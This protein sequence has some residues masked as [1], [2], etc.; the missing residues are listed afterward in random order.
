MLSAKSNNN[1]GFAESF[2]L[3]GTAAGI[4]KTSAAPIERVKLLLQNQNEL[5]K[6]G[7]LS[8]KFTGVQDCVVKTLRN[9]GIRSFWRGN[10]ASVVRY[11]PQQALNFTFK[12]QIK[13][14]FKLPKNATNKEK[15]ATNIMS[16][17]CAGSLSLLFVQ[18]IDYT[19]TRLAMDAAKNAGKRTRQFNGIIDCYVKTMKAD[20]IRGLYRGFVISCIC[21]FIYRGLYFGLYD[22]LKPIILGN[23]K[24]IPWVH[25]FLLGWGV[26]IV[27][28]LT[29]YPIDTVKRRMMMTSGEKTKYAGSIDCF[30]Q[31]IRHEGGPKT[32]FRGCGVNVVRGVA[33]AGV[34]SG[35]DKLKIVY[36]G[37]RLQNYTA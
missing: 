6:Q 5:I 27:S 16:G 31:I 23:R 8:S 11:F 28:G 4:S 17:G 25:T 10:F 20:G 19:R 15:F 32:L 7:K 36:V 3:S 34:L 29:A 37:W 22:S 2:V 12:D 9:E 30:R 26:T 1:L 18:S 13:A 14:I 21:I 24:D 33:G 35:F